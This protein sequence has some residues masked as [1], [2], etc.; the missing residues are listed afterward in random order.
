MHD[1]KS[2]PHCAVVVALA[3]G[4]FSHNAS[5]MRRT[6][7]RAS[8]SGRV[9]SLGQTTAPAR[10]QPTSDRDGKSSSSCIRRFVVHYVLCQSVFERGVVPPLVQRAQFSCDSHVGMNTKDA[11]A[12]ARHAITQAQTQWGQPR[13]EGS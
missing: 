6:S 5:F 3:F 7:A 10:R 13:K 12:T 9:S 4:G 2:S 8:E 11:T 1:K